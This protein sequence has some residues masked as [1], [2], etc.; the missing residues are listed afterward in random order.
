[1]LEKM[2]GKPGIKKYWSNDMLADRPS[3]AGLPV[4]IYKA[5]DDVG[6]V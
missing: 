3:I 6:Y 4:M 1:M 2:L 5:E